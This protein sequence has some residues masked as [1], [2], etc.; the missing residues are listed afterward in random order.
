MRI[1]ISK[2]ERLEDQKTKLK[3]A[4]KVSGDVQVEI[5]YDGVHALNE[6][7][8]SIA[9][10]HP[11]KRSIAVLGAQPPPVFGLLKGFVSEGFSVQEI[12]FSF[13]G[14]DEKAL[15][16]SWEKLKKDTL[17]VL[18]S[19]IE[20]LTGGIYPFD[21]IRREAPKKNIFS[22]MYM[23]SDALKL[24]PIVPASP[25]ES[26]IIDPLWDQSQTLALILKGERSQGER[27]IWGEARF[28]NESVEKLESRLCEPLESQDRSTVLDF[29][30][31]VMEYFK[32]TVR[33][34]DRQCPRVFDRAVLFISGVNGESL[35]H[36]LN[37]KSFDVGSGAS[38]AW[39]SPHFNRWLPKL[40]VSEEMVQTSILIPLKTLK[41]PGLFE[42][43]V[44]NI[45]KLR[46]L[47]GFSQ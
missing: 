32:S 40:G 20:P 45:N 28:S 23:S 10:L 11:H 6:L 34:L 37:E 17:F 36:A 33:S 30:K 13:M 5:A 18:G 38:C 41:K 14:F 15:I 35:M 9:Q 39:D 19:V 22:L 43:L 8:R 29:E 16:E 12:P 3:A 4:L 21:W 24:G 46:K 1:N 31:K 27:L 44:E 2:F 7:T 42:N 26:V 47:S 25:W